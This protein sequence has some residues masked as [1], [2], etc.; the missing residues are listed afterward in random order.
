MPD[1]AKDELLVPT[2]ACGI[3]GSALQQRDALEV[4]VELPDGSWPIDR[5]EVKRVMPT[6]PPI[7]AI[8]PVITQGWA[9][10]QF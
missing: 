2:K 8:F 5:Y 3:Y 7:L 1:L 10:I 9:Y 6:Q 4:L